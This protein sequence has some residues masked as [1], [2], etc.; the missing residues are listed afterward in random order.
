MELDEHGEGAVVGA[1]DHVHLPGGQ[2]PFERPFHQ[3]ARQPGGA[4]HES[5]VPVERLR[6]G[7]PHPR[8]VPPHVEVLV[9]E[10]GRA[11]DRQQYI[12]DPHPQPWNRGGA[13]AQQFRHGLGAHA[14]RR[15]GGR[16]EDGERAEVHGVGIGF[17]VPEGQV[18]GC[19]QLSAQ[20]ILMSSKDRTDGRA[21]NRLRSVT[22]KHR[23]VTFCYCRVV[24]SACRARTRCPLGPALGMSVIRAIR[25]DR[26][27]RATRFIRL[28]HLIRLPE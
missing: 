25:T 22:V 1:A 18:E 17:E 9:H 3:F 12:P 11:A 21:V 5:V 26:T 24:L 16:R 6:L 14:V 27:D 2:A 20:R 4:R 8:D 13:G 28:I 7:Q 19:Q 15:V 23:H 10:P